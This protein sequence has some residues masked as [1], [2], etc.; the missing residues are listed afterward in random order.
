MRAA[1]SDP[2]PTCLAGR[3]EPPAEP[4]R[5]QWKETEA[6]APDNTLPELEERAMIRTPELNGRPY[7]K[8]SDETRL[9]KPGNHDSA[10]ALKEPSWS[11]LEGPASSV[12]AGVT[13]VTRQEMESECPGVYYEL[14]SQFRD[15]L[16]ARVLA[17]PQNAMIF[18]SGFDVLPG[19]VTDLFRRLGYVEGAEWPMWKLVAAFY[20]VEV[21][22]GKGVAKHAGEKIYS[23]MPWPPQ[24]RTVA[25][26]LR[27]TETAYYESHLKAPRWL[28]GCWRVEHETPTS[29]VLTD[30]TP[31]PCYLN[32]GV[33]AGIVRAFSRQRPRY[34]ILDETDAKRAGGT[35]TRYEVE[36]TPA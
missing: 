27:F 18:R 15:R 23:T 11:R 30:D 29:I 36:F 25:D 2:L 16:P 26:A 4:T 17:S 28:A 34:R 33:V 6:L 12:R 1:P 31:Y 14:P 32:E 19:L 24:V 3:G 5:G 9:A 8:A 21:R 20:M 10:A 35:F 13:Y 22:I 7:C